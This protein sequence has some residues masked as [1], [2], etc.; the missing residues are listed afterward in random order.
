MKIASDNKAEVFLS[1]RRDNGVTIRQGKSQVW[2]SEREALEVAAG[3]K[4]L[5]GGKE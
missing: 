4:E 1:R 3:L 5:T 2:L